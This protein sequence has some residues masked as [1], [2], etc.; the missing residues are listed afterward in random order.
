LYEFKSE[1]PNALYLSS[2]FC[3]GFAYKN[4]LIVYLIE[5]ARNSC[6]GTRSSKQANPSVAITLF[7]LRDM[8]LC[9]EQ[10]GPSQ[11][12]TFFKETTAGYLY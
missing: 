6:L 2:G 9:E 12:L 7:I 4:W 8:C 1:P 11:H 5:I 3:E 10:T